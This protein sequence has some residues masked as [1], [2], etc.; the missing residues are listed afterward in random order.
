MGHCVSLP[1]SCFISIY[2]TQNLLAYITPL[3]SRSLRLASVF[4]FPFPYIN[5]T[6][7]VQFHILQFCLQKFVRA[8]LV[9]TLTKLPGPGS[10]PRRPIS[11]AWGRMVLPGRRAAWQAA[12]KQALSLHGRDVAASVYHKFITVATYWFFYRRVGEEGPTE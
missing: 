11:L 9:Q 3:C 7:F 2:W 6:T 1:P 4:C 8:C 10:N 12:T 5:C